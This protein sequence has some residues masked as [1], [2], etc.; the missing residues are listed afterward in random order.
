[1][2]SS[3]D[4]PAYLYVVQRAH[5]EVRDVAGH[6]CFVQEGLLSSKLTTGREHP[7]MRAIL[8]DDAQVASVLDGTLGLANDA[9]HAAT[10]LDCGVRGIEGAPLLHA[11]LEEGVPRLARTGWPAAARISVEL[12]NTLDV[13][14]A[15]ADGEV[16]VVTLDPMMSRAKKSAPSFSLLRD[17]ALAERATPELLAEAS[18]VARRR[19]VLKLGKGAPLP[20]HAPYEFERFERGAHVTYWVHQT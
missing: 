13:L 3:A 17:F 12:G 7:Y 9:L 1:M 16:D 5:D 11:L 18:R 20:P 14:R 2:F 19:V 10:V 4:E 6:T 8:G 15:C